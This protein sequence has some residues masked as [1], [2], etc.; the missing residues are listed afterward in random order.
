MFCKEESHSTKSIKL[1]LSQGL[2]FTILEM[3]MKNVYNLITDAFRGLGGGEHREWEYKV[4]VVFTETIFRSYEITI[5]SR[6]PT[7]TGTAFLHLM[8]NRQN[9]LLDYDDTNDLFLDDNW[10]RFCDVFDR[11]MVHLLLNT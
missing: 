6:D 3:P 10:D 11:Q 7:V 9:E 2:H 8:L 1:N 4:N 5:Q